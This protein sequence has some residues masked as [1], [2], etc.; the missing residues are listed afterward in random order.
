MQRL[1]VYGTLAPGRVNHSVIEHIPGE[2]R[3]A[4][5]KG[6]LLDRGWGAKMG[7][8]GIV[9]CEE[10]DEVEGFILTSDRLSE[11]WAMLDDFEGEGY[12]RV[13]AIVRIENGQQVESFV[14]ALDDSP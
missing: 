10:G 12:R 2:W 14:Y 3:S 8:P 9:P 6:K 1:F 7:C 13:S 11:H 4:T 5:L